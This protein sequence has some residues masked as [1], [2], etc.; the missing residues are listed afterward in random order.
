MFLIPKYCISHKNP[1]SVVLYKLLFL[2]SLVSLNNQVILP[3]QDQWFKCLKKNNAIWLIN[4]SIKTVT[5]RSDSGPQVRNSM[6][7]LNRVMLKSHTVRG[8]STN[9]T[10]KT[11]Q[12][13]AATTRKDCFI[14]RRQIIFD[15]LPL[16]H[17]NIRKRTY[18]KINMW[19]DKE[20]FHCSLLNCHC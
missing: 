19:M 16:I 13:T 15:K 14:A 2:G 11:S 10:L 6:I 3:S 17:H 4:H 20:M 12:T 1:I 5:L 7:I 8:S 9:I 18:Q